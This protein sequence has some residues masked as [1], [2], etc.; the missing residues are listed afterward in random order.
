[1]DMAALLHRFFFV[2]NLNK[3]FD[4]EKK[5][6]FMWLMAGSAFRSDRLVKAFWIVNGVVWSECLYCFTTLFEL[7]KHNGV[8]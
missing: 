5:M 7:N 3:S 1:M 8:S 6:F 4:F 2:K